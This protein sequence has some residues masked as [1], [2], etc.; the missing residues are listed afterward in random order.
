MVQDATTPPDSTSPVLI[1]VSPKFPIQNDLASARQI[2][3]KTANT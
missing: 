2:T 3:C 1:Y